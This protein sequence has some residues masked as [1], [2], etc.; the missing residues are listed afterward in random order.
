MTPLSMVNAP[1]ATLQ[2]G[3]LGAGGGALPSWIDTAGTSAPPMQYGA[4]L[5]QTGTV[6]QNMGFF[7]NGQGLGFNAPTASMALSGLQTLAGLWGGLQQLKLA[8]KSFKFTKDMAET[9]LGNQMQSYNTALADR[10]RS[11]G[12]MEGQ[13]QGQVENYI[14]TNSLTR[15]TGRAGGATPSAIAAS[16]TSNYPGN[17][18]RDPNG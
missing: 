10:A 5:G 8:K 6:A 16:A 3:M 15:S 14:G 7:G 12:V 13:T 2:P 4:G 18:D 1:W 11:R 17:P 9:N